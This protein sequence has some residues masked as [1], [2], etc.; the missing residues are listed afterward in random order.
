M[1]WY[2]CDS[3]ENKRIIESNFFEKD[4]R[5]ASIFTYNSERN[6]RRNRYNN[7]FDWGGNNYQFSQL[8]LDD[9]LNNNNKRIF[10]K[11]GEFICILLSILF[12]IFTLPIS[13]FFALKFVNPYQNAVVMRLGKC[14]KKMHGQGMM[15]LLPFIDEATIVD[16]RVT[17]IELPTIYLFTSDR[18]IL[19]ISS[20]LLTHLLLAVLFRISNNLLA[21]TALQRHLGKR[22]VTD[23]T[24]PKSLSKHV[25]NCHSELD[26]F[27]QKFGLKISAIN[28]TKINVIKAGE[29]GAVS[30]FKTLIRSD[31]GKQFL[32]VFGSN[33]NDI[34]SKV[35]NNE[36]TK[37]TVETFSTTSTIENKSSSTSLEDNIEDSELEQLLQRVRLVLFKNSES[38][39]KRVNKCFRIKCTE[40]SNEFDV[41]LR[42]ANGGWCGWTWQRKESLFDVHFTLSKSTLFSLVNN[43]ITPISAYINGLVQIRGSIQDAILLKNLADFSN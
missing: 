28:I 26:K 17:T 42:E 32:G 9:D 11:L 43:Q 6:Y 36:E 31:V 30:V 21:Y 12:L 5:F 40:C 25:A 14:K 41:D 8:I 27:I 19:E 20:V 39:L 34:V 33:L 2:C 10:N 22:M 15:L 13:L 3:R 29:N 1:F 23:I 35:E 4:Y 18:G 24:N 7:E 16:L 38:L 37:K